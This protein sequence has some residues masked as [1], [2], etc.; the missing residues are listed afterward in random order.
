MFRLFVNGSDEAEW[1]DVAGESACPT[2][3]LPHRLL[4]LSQALSFHYVRLTDFR[5]YV[6]RPSFNHLMY[7]MLHAAINFTKNKFSHF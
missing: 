5:A 3:L 2:T 4:Q 1:D 7:I 6:L